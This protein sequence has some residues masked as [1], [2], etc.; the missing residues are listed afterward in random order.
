MP[1]RSIDRERRLVHAAVRLVARGA[2]SRVTVTGLRHGARL[3]GED[4]LLAIETGVD[5]RA[6]PGHG[7]DLPSRPTPRG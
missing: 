2:A 4:E 6:D 5:I 1:D 7:H 3:V